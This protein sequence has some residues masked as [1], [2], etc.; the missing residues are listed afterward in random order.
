VQL[1]GWLQGMAKSEAMQFLGKPTFSATLAIVTVVILG[2]IGF[3]A[4]YFPARRATS[5]QPAQVLRYE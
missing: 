1:L 2:I 4:G 3:L 5:I